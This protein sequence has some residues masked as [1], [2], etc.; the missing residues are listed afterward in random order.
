MRA[1]TLLLI[2][3]CAA[4]ASGPNVF[5]AGRGEPQAAPVDSDAPRV[6]AALDAGEAEAAVTLVEA[7]IARD[8]AAAL[9]PALAVRVAKLFDLTLRYEAG[10]RFVEARAEAGL[11]DGEL[12]RAAAGLFSETGRIRLWGELLD[13]ALEKRT[14][15]ARLL[16]ERARV[17]FSLLE[18]EPALAIVGRIAEPSLKQSAAATYLRGACL[19][20]LGRWDSALEALD[21]CLAVDADHA[22]ARFERG[23]VL[24]RLE[25][26]PEAI[27][28]FETM[29]L[30]GRDPPV[31][32]GLLSQLGRALH[33]VGRRDEARFILD[34][35]RQANVEDERW[36]DLEATLRLDPEQPV[37]IAD[38]VEFGLDHRISQRRLVAL[39]ER[40]LQLCGG[41]GP[42][43]ARLHVVRGR[44]HRRARRLDP[45]KQSFLAAL[46]AHRDAHAARLEL[47]E[48]SL[49]VGAIE[50][51][52]RF[53]SR[54]EGEVDPSRWLL[55]RAELEA[56]RRQPADFDAI[57]EFVRRAIDA[58]PSHFEAMVALVDVGQALGRREEV[59]VELERRAG[60]T[61]D[62]PNFALARA[63]LAIESAEWEI[64]DEWLARAEQIDPFEPRL[65]H[66][67]SVR[68]QRGSDPKAAD[69]ARRRARLYHRILGR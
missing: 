25:R 69:A 68:H 16:L 6:R 29:L 51:A 12:A 4:A 58:D 66:Y 31:R 2:V 45:A 7:W 9:D 32:A 50:F 36:K 24:V 47:A 52:D 27:A 67:R 5:G 22:R 34:A 3:W 13:G 38:L 49:S 33:R 37:A 11:L 21:R 39:I 26:Y 60:A 35:F 28:T 59:E 10:V 56:R 15:D 54:S 53:L 42:V 20:G 14:Q 62:H 46:E 8:G 41:R 44:W 17:A 55:A 57:A 64:A 1:S 40:G 61:E 23:R 65:H 30:E 19:A 63:V 48:L 43:A 18:Y